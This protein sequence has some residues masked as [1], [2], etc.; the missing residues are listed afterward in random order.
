MYSGER[1]RTWMNK[2]KVYNTRRLA[3]LRGEG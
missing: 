1:L 2:A 3:G